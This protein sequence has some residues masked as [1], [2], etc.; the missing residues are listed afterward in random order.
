MQL[1][2]C[3]RMRVQKYLQARR[4]CWIPWFRSYNGCQSSEIGARIEPRSSTGAILWAVSPVLVIFKNNL[5]I[6]TCI[7]A[8]RGQL[9]GVT[10]VL[11]SCEGPFTSP[12]SFQKRFSSSRRKMA[13]AGES[14]GSLSLTLL[15]H[16]SCSILNDRKQR[17]DRRQPPHLR[18]V[19]YLL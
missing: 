18:S 1:C 11:P 16:S 5:S 13:R 15:L 10:Y 4:G 19:H 8:Q 6:L 3:L 17:K 12:L 7:Y 2:V 9:V 14:P